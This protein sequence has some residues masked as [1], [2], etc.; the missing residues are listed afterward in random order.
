MSGSGAKANELFWWGI[1]RGDGLHHLGLGRTPWG[2]DSRARGKL[3]QKLLCGATWKF[4]PKD[5]DNWGWD[6]G[7]ATT[8]REGRAGY[9]ID[10][11]TQLA[12]FVERPNWLGLITEALHIAG[13]I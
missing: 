13:R 7:E 5:Y 1:A 3:N 12:T 4:S 11:L 10:C 2:P 6:Y 9:C 8:I